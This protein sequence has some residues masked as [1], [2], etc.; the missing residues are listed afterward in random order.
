MSKNLIMIIG[1]LLLWLIVIRN[2]KFTGFPKAEEKEE[3][4]SKTD[5]RYKDDDI[6]TSHEQ[7]TAGSGILKEGSTRFSYT[8]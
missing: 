8:K 5:G 3:T 6:K 4:T 7:N 2:V 1:V